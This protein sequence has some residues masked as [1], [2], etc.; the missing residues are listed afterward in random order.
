MS[1]L[2]GPVTFEETSA[3]ANVRLAAAVKTGLLDLI[4]NIE[5]LLKRV[6]KSLEKHQTKQKH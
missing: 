3:D 1:P 5:L 4:L 2:L 6:N